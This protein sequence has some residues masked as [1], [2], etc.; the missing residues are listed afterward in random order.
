MSS[1]RKETGTPAQL[2]KDLIRFVMLRAET[3]LM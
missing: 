1:E 2:R 3:T